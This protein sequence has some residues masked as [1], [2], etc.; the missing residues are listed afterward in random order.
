M[1]DSL[2]YFLVALPSQLALIYVPTRLLDIRHKGWYWAIELMAALPLLLVRDYVGQPAWVLFGSMTMVVPWIAFA[3]DPLPRRLFA[4]AMIVLAVALAEIPPSL[5]WSN[6]AGADV[7]VAPVPSD[8]LEIFLAAHLLHLVVLVALL[9]ILVAV[10]RWVSLTSTRDGISQFIGFIVVQCLLVMLSVGIMEVTGDLSQPIVLGNLVVGMT[11]VVA[12]GLF[13]PFME[14]YN[15]MVREDERAQMLSYEL[16]HYLLR[17]REIEREVSA[18]ARVRHDLR[19]QANVILM[20]IDQGAVSKARGYVDELQGRVVEMVDGAAAPALEGGRPPAEEDG[21]E[22]AADDDVPQRR[23]PARLTERFLRTPRRRALA[24]LVFPLSQLAVLAFLGWF[25]AAYEP[26]AWVGGLVALVTVLCVLADIVLFR[27]LVAIDEAELA[28]ERVRLLEE[29]RELQ[30]AYF[31]RLRSGLAEARGMRADIMGTLYEVERCLADGRAQEA[32]DVITRAIDGMDSAD[33]HYCENRVVDALLG[34]KL[35]ACVEAGIAVD[36]QV[37]IPENLAI[38][39][40]DLCA[41]FANLM[42]NAIRSCRMVEGPFRKIVLKACLVSGVL[43][44]DLVNGRAEDDGPEASAQRDDASEPAVFGGRELP[45]P[46]HGWGLQIL[47]SLVQRYDGSLTTSVEDGRWFR[48]T[49]M[50]I[51][52]RPAKMPPGGGAFSE[53]SPGAIGA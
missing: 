36:C 30:R 50:L 45:V 2:I 31:E 49:V 19:N 46:A 17:Y 3:R 15:L 14:R 11:C 16:S 52:E 12:D 38:L 29:Q 6:V 39:D 23:E 20:L 34:M 25:V 33:G 1:P 22:D 48:T 51:N 28:V 35:R 26:A 40:V 43:M 53:G 10:G 27:A 13:F 4:T 7:S 32:A 18:V 47:R 8:N 9:A 24:S 41:V 37:V 42:D 5:L 44:V 21:P